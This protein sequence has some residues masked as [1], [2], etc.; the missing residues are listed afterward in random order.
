MSA[1]WTVREAYGATAIYEGPRLVCVL[2]TPN[3]TDVT[4]VASEICTAHNATLGLSSEEKLSMA[5]AAVVMQVA[6]E[7]CNEAPRNVDK[8]GAL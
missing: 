7:I 6:S 5:R 2:E 8:D 3:P 1:I 4:K